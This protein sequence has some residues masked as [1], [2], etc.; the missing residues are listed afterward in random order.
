MVSGV[1]LMPGTL[2]D[3]IGE[4]ETLLVFLR[5]FGCMF[6][7]EMVS[8]IRSAKEANPKYPEVLFFFQGSPTEGR[9][10]LRRY[11]PDVR[12]IADEDQSFY[13]DFGVDRGNLLQIF[14]PSAWLSS[15]RAR[16][17]GHAPGERSGDIMRMPGLFLVRGAEILWS[18][19]FAH[20]ADHPDFRTLPDEA[21]RASA[22][23]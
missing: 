2:A 23:A 17:K 1:N 11:W 16:S 20:Q 8:D 4:S 12:A 14:G 3:Q 5:H 10:F 21:R 15:S 9:A 6:C 13:T 22:P 7:R 19:R 18:H